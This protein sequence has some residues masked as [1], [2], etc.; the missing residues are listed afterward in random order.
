M[1]LTNTFLT[2]I[3]TFIA[4]V[5]TSK[6]VILFIA[7][8]S[9]LVVFNTS[10][11]KN[12][13][14]THY[15]VCGY[16]LYLPAAFIYNDISEYQFFDTMSIKYNFTHENNKYGLNYNETTKKYTTNYSMYIFNLI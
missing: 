14:F 6:V 5:F 13:G 3:I 12:E 2:K 9:I 15:D 10:R 4:H 7:I 1:N 16:Y 8:N 11:F